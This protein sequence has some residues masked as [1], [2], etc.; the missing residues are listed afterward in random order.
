M[1]RKA[2]KIDAQY[3][4]E[5]NIDCWKTAYKGIF[6]DELLNNLELKKDE[7][8]IKC[9]N[10][11]EEYIVYELNSKIVGFLR[12][13]LNKKDYSNEYGEIY[14]IYVDN[15]Y[16]G[17]GIGIELINYVNN[18]LKENYKYVLV[19][20]LISNKANDFYKKVGFEKID[21]SNFIL[22]EKNMKKM[23]IV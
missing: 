20:T 14:A 13:G 6:P 21:K 23:Y 16:Q 11:I 2:S 7:S 4:V 3:I 15:C 8:I 18:I 22:N 12:Y 19:S 1:I 10:N 17:N 5:I 9:Q